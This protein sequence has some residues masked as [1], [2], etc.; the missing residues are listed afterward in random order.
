MGK[1]NCVTVISQALVS[2]SKME[3]AFHTFRLYQVGRVGWVV[4]PTSSSGPMSAK[5]ITVFIVAALSPMVDGA[6]LVYMKSGTFAGV[7]LQNE[8]GLP[9]SGGS[10][11][12]GNGTLLEFGY[13]SLASASDPFSGAWNAL[14]GPNS[15]SLIITTIGDQAHPDGQFGMSFY[16]DPASVGLLQDGTPLAIRF[17][18]STSRTNS[19]FF[20]T[21][22]NTTGSWNWNSSAFQIDMTV[23]DVPGIV[24]QDGVGSAFLTTIA[25]PEPSAFILMGC[26]VAV[27]AGIRRRA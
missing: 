12:S 13:Y 21:V 14:T 7:I 3:I 19:T 22:S 24:W 17:F 2:K 10:A 27:W 20:N 26:G 1:A 8:S 4:L 18:N 15:V 6:T 9:L 16:L 25:V 23:G 5:L 11:A